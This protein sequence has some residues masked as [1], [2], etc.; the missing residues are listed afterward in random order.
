MVIVLIDGSAA[1]KRIC[2]REWIYTAISRAKDTCYLVGDLRVAQE[3]TKRTVTDKRK[4]FLAE[5]LQDLLS[6]QES[7][8][9]ELVT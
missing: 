6:K 9:E 8:V 3:F 5:M 1:A 2:T 7:V 4:T